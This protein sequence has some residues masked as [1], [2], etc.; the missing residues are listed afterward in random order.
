MGN[1]PI[2]PG[3]ECTTCLKATIVSLREELRAAVAHRRLALGLARLGA[4]S[5]HLVGDS[6][7]R[8]TTGAARRA[9]GEPEP[10]WA[11]DGWPR[12][13]VPARPCVR[14]RRRAVGPSRGRGPTFDPC[15]GPQGHH[16]RDRGARGARVA[17]PSCSALPPCSAACSTLAEHISF[18]LSRMFRCSART[19]MRRHSQGNTS[20]FHTCRTQTG[21]NGGTVEHPR[22]YSLFLFHP[23]STRWNT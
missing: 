8:P 1:R 21:R 23:L 6:L 15:V 16:R 11:R 9:P 19:A 20:R 4:P 2:K 3:C 7:G 5:P 22:N 18:V 14:V 10:P 12:V 17:H 13:R